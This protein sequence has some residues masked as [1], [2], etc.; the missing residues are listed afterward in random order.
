[1]NVKDLLQDTGGNKLVPLRTAERRVT[2]EERD[3]RPED[4][5]EPARR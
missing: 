2:W 5:E 3:K 4:W 1:M